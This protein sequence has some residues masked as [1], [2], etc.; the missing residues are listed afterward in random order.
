MN[1]VENVQPLDNYLLKVTFRNGEIRQFDMKPYLDKGIFNE[2]K[3][4]EVFK[5][6]KPSFDTVEW[7]NEADIDP[8][9]LYQESIKIGF[10]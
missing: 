8:E 10:A 9:I 4:V 6:V 5:T 3:D 2:L 7:D 1:S